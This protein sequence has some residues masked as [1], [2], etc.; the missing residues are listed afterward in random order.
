MTNSRRISLA[1]FA[2]L[3]A[4]GQGCNDS[5]TA[6]RS[7]PTALRKMAGD[8]QSAPVG[9]AVTTPPS[10]VVLDANQKPVAGVAVTFAV[11][12]GGGS[13]T[14]GFDTSDASGTARVGSWRLGPTVGTDTLTATV[15]GLP[16]VTFT[17]TATPGSD[18][19]LTKQ[20]GDGQTATVATAV[21]TPPAVRVSDGQDKPESGVRVVFQITAGG[22]TLT[23]AS[24]M[25]DSSGIAAVGA[26]ILGTAS[27]TDTLTAT[28]TGLAPVTFT[29]TGT[30]GPA[31]ALA[32][33]AG[34]NTR[35]AVGSPVAP[36]PAVLVSDAF[37]N[38]VAGASVTFA[39]ASGGG[40][41][42][43]GSATSA[44][45]GIAT[46]G[47]WTLGTVPGTN[48]LAATATGMPPV[49]FTATGAAGPAATITAQAGDGQTANINSSVAVLPA[50]LV[51][52]A[53]NNPVRGA[54]VTFLVT[55]GGGSVQGA[56]PTTD[57]R[58]IATAGAWALG[59]AAGINTLTATVTGLPPVT[60]TATG[61]DNCTTG[62]AYAIGS[63]VAGMLSTGDCDLGGGS[64]MDLY[65]A[66]A[67]ATQS[68]TF[69]MS[70]TAFFTSLSLFD[71]SGSI[72]TSASDYC[73]DDVGC[74]I[75]SS[76]STFRALLAPGTYLLGASASG[77]CGVGSY[78]LSSNPVAED[79]TGCT[80]VWITTGVTTSQRID[81]TDCTAVFRL[82]TYYSD[83]FSINLT[84]GRTY[85]F[86]MSSADFDTYLELWQ[87]GQVVAF[88]DDF[89]GTSNSQIT[90]TPTVSGQYV[91]NAATFD[92]AKTG[93]YTLTVQ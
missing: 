54:A 47:S 4:L 34:D 86:S 35:D 77:C 81:T 58:G 50:A 42:T 67:P 78:S 60:F 91:I 64:Y 40:S 12:A 7:A 38:P 15:A 21:A 14:G 2:A 55:S 27:R 18:W 88:N 93:A 87:W 82:A 9:A 62:T 26:W 61:I 30:A 17:A 57:T 49:T 90:F 71:S 44:G 19:I 11:T 28:V 59:P 13:L 75:V 25:T 83:Q 32:R 23:A 72:V 89:G 20:I 53:F 1:L 52:D 69:T 80:S 39:V 24:P 74:T 70:S 51:R 92:A 43:G 68:V 33:Q 36:A 31:A 22:G 29:A 65:A 56:T 3:L 16:A 76:S 41:V 66:T 46:V 84:A 5:G 8:S 37:G 63:S 85:T 73:T 45:N 6:V 79:V 10:A 48:T